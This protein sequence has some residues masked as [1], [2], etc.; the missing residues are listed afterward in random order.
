MSVAELPIQIDRE[1]IARFCRERG[2]RKLCLFGSVV[3]DDFDPQRSDVM[4]WRSL[5]R[6]F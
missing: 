5:S 4:C 3:H 6:A 1:R 2:I